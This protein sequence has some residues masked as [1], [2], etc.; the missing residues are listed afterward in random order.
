MRTRKLWELSDGERRDLLMRAQPDLTRAMKAAEFIVQRVR[1]GGDAALLRWTAEFDGV[2][3][4]AEQLRV[5]PEEFDRAM[6]A[7]APEL[8]RAIDL[9][10][11]NIRRFHEGT[12]PQRTHTVEMGDGLVCTERH[13][14]IDSVCLYVPRGRGSFSSVLC[15]LGVP[16]RLAGVPRII[17]CTPPGPEGEVDS[18]TLYAA[19]VIGIDEIYRVGGA[20][21]VA[22]VAFGTE[23]IPMCAKIV[24]PANVYATAAK[25]LLA[26]E[27]DPGP[28]AGPSESIIL[29]DDSANPHNVALNLLV[30]AEHGENSCALLVT[31]HEPLVHSVAE[32]VEQE[33][34]QLAP[35]RAEYARRVLNTYGGAVLTRSLDESIAFT[36]EFAVEHL[37]IMT[38]DPQAACDRITNAGEILIGTF[39]I[40]SLANYVVGVNAIL[41][42][43]RYARTESPVSVR[44][45]MKAASIVELREPAYRRFVDAV[46]AFGDHEGFCAHQRAAQHWQR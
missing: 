35:Q 5:A 13:T 39:P 3:L 37:A 30:E 25:R 40:I 20:Q 9:A 29:C 36:N 26:D 21:A 23:T 43:S 32:I 11:E 10:I 15:M 4:T 42:T 38:R 19:R 41:P 7:T 16:A 18:A 31:H 8:R 44:D 34:G 22:A 33:L 1:A 6:D 2:E 27:I 14:P 24:G 12:M 28:G 17:V 46:V 45:F